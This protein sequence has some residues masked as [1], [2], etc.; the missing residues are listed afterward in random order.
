M[1]RKR[2]SNC[3]RGASPWTSSVYWPAVRPL[4][5]QSRSLR[6]RAVTREQQERPASSRLDERQR[7]RDHGRRVAAVRG[8]RQTGRQE[9]ACLGAEVERALDAQCASPLGANALDE[10]AEIVADRECC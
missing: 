9:D 10:V 6:K 7:L 5:Q 4:A 3:S 1:V 2:A 8:I